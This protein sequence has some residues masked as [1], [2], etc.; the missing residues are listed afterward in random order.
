MAI[1]GQLYRQLV[2]L[3]QFYQ[4][5]P[6]DD[7]S[8]EPLSDAAVMAAQYERLTQFQRL[9][10][11][12]HP[13]LRDLALANCGTLQKRSVLQPALEGL[14]HDQLSH[15]VTRQL[16]WVHSAFWGTLRGILK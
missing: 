6:I 14:P 7:Q 4:Y 3:F 12:H 10:F 8:G 15:L 11:K 1:A 5:F 2:D 13:Q 9:L 16:R